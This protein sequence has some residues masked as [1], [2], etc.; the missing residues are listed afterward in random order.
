[1]PGLALNGIQVPAEIGS[2]ERPAPELIGARGRSP[3][4]GAQDGVRS[5][6]QLFRGRLK[7]LPGAEADAWRGLLGGRGHHF[8]FD[9]NLYS[10]RG[11]GPSSSSGTSIVAGGK[12]GA[13]LRLAATTGQVTYGLVSTAWTVLVWRY[14]SA[15][16]H[17]YIVRS[18]AAAWVDGSAT[19]VPAWLVV[20][21][22]TKLTNTAGSA[23]DFDDLVVL[24]YLMPSGWVADVYAEHSAQAWAPVPRLRLTGDLVPGAPLTVSGGPGDGGRI[25]SVQSGSFDLTAETLEFE[26][27]EV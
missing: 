22:S 3:A 4:G 20:S 14:E 27:R 13:K 6:K 5:R 26:L 24:P 11:L 23:Q 2:V 15:A 9:V 10:D 16:W 21:G 12:F 8:S 25:P 1:V 19:S 17:H 7:V 18:D